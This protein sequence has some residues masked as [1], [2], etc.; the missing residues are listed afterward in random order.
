M[1]VHRNSWN[2]R[3]SCHH[4]YLNDMSFTAEWSWWQSTL[5]IKWLRSNWKL[6]DSKS[7][8][9]SHYCSL[10]QIKSHC[11]FFKKRKCLANISFF[12]LLSD[13]LTV[14]EERVLNWKHLL[15]GGYKVE[16]GVITK[17]IFKIF[18]LT[19]CVSFWGLDYYVMESLK[20]NETRKASLQLH[21]FVEDLKYFVHRS[22]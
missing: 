1:S 15:D 13:S 6:H 10:C 3:S 18:I 14:V 16:V 4:N 5:I 19:I 20:E 22:K 8:Y 21:K 9:C 2:V 12:S 17:S 11:S 7:T